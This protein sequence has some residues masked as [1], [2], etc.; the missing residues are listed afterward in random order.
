MAICQLVRLK[1]EKIVFLHIFKDFE[2]VKQIK[3]D[4]KRENLK[5]QLNP[6]WRKCFFQFKISKH[7]YFCTKN[8][9]FIDYKMVDGAIFTIF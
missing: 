9:T 2:M 7:L 8:S 1:S 4:A 6:R 3:D 5:W